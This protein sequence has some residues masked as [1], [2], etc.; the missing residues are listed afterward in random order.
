MAT[1][2][3]IFGIILFL[4]LIVI[5]EF[6]HYIV[7]VRNGV[8]AEEFAIFFGPSIYKKKLK[9]GMLFRFNILPL[10]G[11]V[12]LKG[13]HDSDTGPGTYGAASLWVKTKIMLAGV[14]ANALAAIVLL[15][16][17]ALTGLPQILPNQFTVK[18]NEHIVNKTVVVAGVLKNSP[19][20]KAGIKNGD[21]LVALGPAGHLITISPTNT[22][23][24][25]TKKYAGDRVNIEISRHSVTKILTTI[26]NP[27][28]SKNN[29]Y[30][31]VEFDS[32]SGGI[33]LIRYTWAAPI[34]ALGFTK[35]AIVL[36]YQGLLKVFEGIGGIFAGIATH[37]HV[38]R[39]HAQTSAGNQVVGPYGIYV[40][41]REVSGIGLSFMVL[42]I[43]LLSLTLAIMNVL[44]IPALDGGRLWLTLIF[45]S[46]KKKLTAHTEEMINAIG[47][48]CLMLLVCLLFYVDIKRFH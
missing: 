24:D 42:I 37:N 43:A 5:H 33:S 13:E 28:S 39:E 21:D 38:A 18:S 29:V 41:L 1:L 47:M 16:I 8:E 20:Q 22:L 44:P 27:K 32:F 36:S 3:F 11:Y 6:G 30:L 40:I 45:R 9:S 17:L 10:G 25:L 23:Q 14:T 46:F 2:I 7:A 19:A 12:K 26:L 35:Q 34:V 31:G 48:I 4:F 15:T